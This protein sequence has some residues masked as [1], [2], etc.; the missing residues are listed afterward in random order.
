MHLTAKRPVASSVRTA[1]AK[2][3]LVNALS[4]TVTTTTCSLASLQRRSWGRSDVTPV[5]Y[6]MSDSRAESR[7]MRVAVAP[8]HPNLARWPAARSR[9]GKQRE[10]GKRPMVGEGAPSLTTSPVWP[11]A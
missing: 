5:P 10:Q 4:L 1:L 11:V 7:R 3:R 2:L 6:S 9:T 8:L